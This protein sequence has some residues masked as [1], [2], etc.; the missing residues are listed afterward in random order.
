MFGE[1]KHIKILSLTFSIT[2]S[3]YN[4]KKFYKALVGTPIKL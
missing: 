3:L 4:T 1:L 2:A